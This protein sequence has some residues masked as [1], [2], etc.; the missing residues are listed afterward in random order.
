MSAVIKVG[1]ADYKV[2]NGPDKL[3]TLGLGSCIGITLYDKRKKQG[4]LCEV[5][6]CADYQWLVYFY[7][8]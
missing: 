7:F 8:F 4:D 1:M 5:C 3:L 6:E 2:G